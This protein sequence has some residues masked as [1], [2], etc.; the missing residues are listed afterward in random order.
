[1]SV[2]SR[3]H[4]GAI[5]VP[6]S[7]I[8]IL[9]SAIA[10]RNW[11]G[12]VTTDAIER[13]GARLVYDAIGEGTATVI[14]PGGPGFGS[15]YLRHALPQA[16][17]S[18]RRLIF[19]DQRGS[20]R[21]SGHERPELLTM[22]TFVDDLEAVRTEIGED[23]IDLVGHSFGGLQSL[24]YASRHPKRIGR[25]IL[26]ESDPPTF[27]EWCRFRN[28][29]AIRSTEDVDRRLQSIESRDGWRS[30][31]LCLET[32]FRAYLQ[33]YFGRPECASRLVF[34]F[35]ADSMDKMTIAARSLRA[36]L[37]EWDISAALRSFT[38]PTLIMYG[39][40]SIF[41]KSAVLSMHAALPGAQ[42]EVIEDVGHFPFLED[43]GTFTRI[44]QAFF[45]P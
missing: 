40:K 15:T 14:V 39:E 29:L 31:P 25:L 12:I 24:F 23:R 27:Q 11:C 28:V 10:E 7:A 41:P 16:A 37:G 30:D 17:F 8:R 3:F 4:L 34:G 6:V 38:T 42:F 36:D 20:G 2:R 9:V 22:A 33:P 21:S 1:M 13:L 35:A 26:V 32:Y 19:V 44:V 18:D 5:P 43:P 45:A